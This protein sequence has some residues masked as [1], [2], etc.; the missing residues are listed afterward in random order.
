MAGP[1]LR[2]AS[3]LW[4]GPDG[5]VPGAVVGSGRPGF[6]SFQSFWFG[7]DGMNGNA[8]GG[9]VTPTS[10]RKLISPAFAKT[11]TAELT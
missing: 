6:R 8:G 11:L 3:S 1:G 9:P 5:A 4:F 10:G 7:P 2:S